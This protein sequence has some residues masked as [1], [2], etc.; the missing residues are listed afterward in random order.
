MDALRAAVT[1][2][3][4][5]PRYTRKKLLVES[6]VQPL[7]KRILLIELL[8]NIACIAPRIKVKFLVL[9]LV[10]GIRT[11]KLVGRVAVAVGA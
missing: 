11:P 6:L 4:M 3:W 7:P 1:M 9:R 2:L 10:V 8:S 5:P